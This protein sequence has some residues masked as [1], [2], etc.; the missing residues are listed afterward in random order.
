M[1]FQFF[2]QFNKFKFITNLTISFSRLQDHS[3]IKLSKWTLRDKLIEINAEQEFR[4][5]VKLKLLSQT[6]TENFSS[7]KGKVI[8]LFITGM[9]K[10]ESIPKLHFKKCIQHFYSKLNIKLFL[11]CWL[12]LYQL[13]TFQTVKVNESLYIK[14]YNLKLKLILNELMAIKN[15]FLFK[16]FLQK[17]KIT[18]KLF[19]SV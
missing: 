9:S 16:Y 13:K 1:P 17:L 12:S 15:F 10:S 19:F 18:N 8:G 3:L 2:Y 5:L 11:C 4:I 14:K 6:R 7:K